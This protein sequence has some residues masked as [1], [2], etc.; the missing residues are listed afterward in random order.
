GTFIPLG[1]STDPAPLAICMKGRFSAGEDF[2]S[3]GL[4]THIPDQLII[5]GVQ[6]IVQGHGELHHTQAGPEM[7]AVN[8]DTIDDVLSEFGTELR[9]LGAAEFFQVVWG[10]DLRQ[11]GTGNDFFHSK[12][13]NWCQ[14]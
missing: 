9:Q 14:K 10:I 4:V 1:K 12:K 7:T 13:A 8:T 5:W 11:K 2:V 6:H 3:V